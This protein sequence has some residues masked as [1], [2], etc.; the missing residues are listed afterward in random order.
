MAELKPVRLTKDGLLT[1]AKSSDVLPIEY[2]GTGSSEA[3]S[4]D[5]LLPAQSQSTAGKALVSDGT[6]VTW[7][8]VT[9]DVS[10]KADKTVVIGAGSGLSGGGQIAYDVTLH[11][12]F[13]TGAGTAAR[14]NDARIGS[15]SIETIGVDEIREGI[16]DERK[17][18]TVSRVSEAVDSKIYDR[19]VGEMF[20]A[21][22][23][24][25]GPSVI[26]MEFGGGYYA[27]SFRIDDKV[28]ALICS[29][30]EGH[31]TTNLLWKTANTLTSGA[32]STN[33]GWQNT[34]DMIAA[35]AATHPAANF[36]RNLNI[37]GYD[38]WY[39]P[40]IDELE[41]LYRAFKP[42]T[43]NNSMHTEAHLPHSVKKN[44]YNPN[45]L[46]NGI[47][48]V[49]GEPPQTT[50]DRFQYDNVLAFRDFRGDGGRRFWSST[51]YNASNA[52]YQ[53]FHYGSQGYINR[54]DTRLA[55]RAVRRVL[56]E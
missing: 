3:A 12:D 14:G 25:F 17:S 23:R 7:Q 31:S 2:G 28:Y 44:G 37:N 22:G 24:P 10:D 29:P 11:L 18:L 30:A 9:T 1:I 21:S 40:S 5:S 52:R 20:A 56:I 8:T 50:D 43:Q 27:G 46:P 32:I 55:V 41:M 19:R 49:A 33:D 26:G 15:G 53:D 51:Q 36:C 42:T 39:L 38:D 35:G 47:P 48:Y 16:S 45:S 54:M 34:L 13:G 6:G 4:I